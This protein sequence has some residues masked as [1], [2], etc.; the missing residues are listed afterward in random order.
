MFD[1]IALVLGNLR[2][3]GPI[4]VL[5][6][7]QVQ[8]AY[9]LDPFREGSAVRDNPVLSVEDNQFRRWRWKHLLQQ[10]GKGRERHIN[11][12]NGTTVRTA[13]GERRS[14]LLRLK[15]DIRRGNSSF[16]TLE[17]LCVPRPDTRIKDFIMN[18][19]C[20]DDLERTIQKNIL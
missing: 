13:V 10:I 3:Y 9:R 14:D 6:F 17:T 2:K 5:D 16:A 11:A 15:K 12:G 20:F 8:A 19:S 7:W 1:F 4:A 18:Y